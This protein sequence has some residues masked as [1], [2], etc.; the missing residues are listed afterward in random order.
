RLLMA[1][2]GMRRVRMCAASR[3]ACICPWKRRSKSGEGATPPMRDEAA[4][5]WGTRVVVAQVKSA[6]GT[7]ADSLL[8]PSQ[9][10]GRGPRYGDDRKKSNSNTGILRLR[11]GVFDSAYSDPSTTRCALRSG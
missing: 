3:R 11:A 10:A 6:A 9:Q 1:V 5:E 4:H 8:H 2:C 7:T